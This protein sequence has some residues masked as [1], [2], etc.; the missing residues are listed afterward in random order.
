MIREVAT[1]DNLRF[2]ANRKMTIILF[3]NQRLVKDLALLFSISEYSFEKNGL[4]H[5]QIFDTRGF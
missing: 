3:Y 5:I 1:F 2:F 4:S